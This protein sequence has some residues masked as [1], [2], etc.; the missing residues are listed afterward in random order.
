[1]VDQGIRRSHRGLTSKTH[2]AKDATEKAVTLSLI[3][4]AKSGYTESRSSAVSV[5]PKTFIANKEYDANPFIKLLEKRQI[6]VVVP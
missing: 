3:A 6:T 1:M 5:A 4:W 2:A